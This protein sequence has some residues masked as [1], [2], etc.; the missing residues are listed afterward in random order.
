MP[1]RRSP[2]LLAAAFVILTTAAASAQTAPAPAMGGMDMSHMKMGDMKPGGAGG[3]DFETAMQKAMAAM[4]KGMNGTMTGDPDR[5]FAAM[6]IPHHQG[7]IDMAEAELRFGKDKRLRKL[8][9]DIVAA[10]KK[11]IA[12]MRAE[13]KKLEAAK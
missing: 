8:A 13:L 5:D 10:Q 4:D 7:A 2:G 1:I 9:H 11:E 12:V 3:D 6:M